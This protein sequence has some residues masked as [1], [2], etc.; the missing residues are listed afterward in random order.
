MRDDVGIKVSVTT[1]DGK[2][3]TAL[4]THR[5]MEAAVGDS[6]A[7]FVSELQTMRS[8]IP[9]GIYFPEEIPSN[10]FR[11]KVLTEISSTSMQYEINSLI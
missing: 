8:Q 2:E 7:A 3:H 11:E 10:S 5:D 9:P 6:I 1:K 4:M